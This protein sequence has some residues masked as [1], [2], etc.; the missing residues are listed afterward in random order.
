MPNPPTTVAG[1]AVVAAD[2]P[3]IRELPPDL[4]DK[5]AAG[6]V[7]ERP[8][9][10][11]KELVE[12]AI[13]AGARRVTVALEDGGK[14]LIRV[15]DDGSGIVEDELAL[16]VK[17]HA[18]SK[19][20]TAD[21]LF[22][23][24]TLGFRGEALAS[25][26]AVS[27][28]RIASC[29]TGASMGAELRKTSPSGS[30]GELRRCAHPRGTTVE[31]RNLFAGV[32]ARR[33]FLK[34]DRAEQKAVEQELE[35]LAL[36][37]FDVDISLESDGKPLLHATPA[38]EPRER[39]AELLSRDLA[40]SLVAIDPRRGAG[41]RLRGYASPLD[42]GRSDGKRQFFFLNGRAVRDRVF[43]GAVR[44]AYANL[45][46]PRRFPVVLL[47][48]EVP[49]SEVD[50]NVHPTKAEVRFRRASDVY[51]LIVSSLR[52]AI[53][54]SGAPAPPL[55]LP[56]AIPGFAGGECGGEGTAGSSGLPPPANPLLFPVERAL[57]P[58]TSGPLLA[59]GRGPEA[60]PPMVRP[61]AKPPMVPGRYVQIHKRYIL[62]ETE[63]GFRL[64][65]PH[66]LH[67]RLLYD[68]ILARLGEGPLEAQRLLFPV[69][70]ELD[71][72]ER[73]ELEDRRALLEA[74]GFDVA[75]FG[76]RSLALH[77]APRLVP[78]GHLPDLIRELLREP[79]ASEAISEDA[80][81]LHVAAG[82]GALAAR[83]REPLARKILHGIAAA[84]ACKAAVKFGDALSGSEIESLLARREEARAA[85]CPH[86]RPTALA[87]TFEEL[88]RRFGR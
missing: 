10:V 47:W 26:A 86:G 68:E 59:P 18:T 75:P 9:S 52:D 63:R 67:E 29:P 48:L 73:R 74:V 15:Q 62:E 31:V 65:D 56:R 28:F 4:V 39:I 38:D 58:V 6:E 30:F 79:R 34:G 2:R 42:R 60:K 16:A 69:I 66:A 57:F 85:C 33:A 82:K 84:L 72:S 24:K 83:A 36:G 76:P 45:L 5:I 77:A 14:K 11:V 13:D 22:A 87:I 8:S 40:E 46:P 19:L 25:I 44:A 12:N 55:M 17:S 32:P 1:P 53:A 23:I 49:P 61:E 71:R 7:V 27:S 35:R 41:G 88:D 51:A 20:G 78:P 50:V 80:T 64:V 43:L 81:A 54:R 37:R 3:R 21:D 70:V